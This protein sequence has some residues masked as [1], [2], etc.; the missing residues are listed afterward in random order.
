MWHKHN[1]TQQAQNGPHLWTIVMLSISSSKCAQSFLWVFTNSGS[2]YCKGVTLVMEPVNPPHSEWP[3]IF[4]HKIFCL[5]SEQSRYH[6]TFTSGKPNNQAEP[7]WVALSRC[8][9]KV[10]QTDPALNF[11]TT[12]S[13]TCLPGLSVSTMLFVRQRSQR[14]FRELQRSN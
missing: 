12:F 4:R 10:S 3:A 6:V 9:W 14:S 7:S 2:K 11:S 13:L 1:S 8:R 5:T